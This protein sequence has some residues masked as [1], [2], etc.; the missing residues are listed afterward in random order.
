MRS[1]IIVVMMV[2]VLVLVA[3][4][5]YFKDST[6][7]RLELEE[8]PESVDDSFLDIYIGSSLVAA[9][10]EL[11]KNP[12]LPGLKLIPDYYKKSSG[13]TIPFLSEPPPQLAG[14]DWIHG[15]QG[16]QQ[17]QWFPPDWQHG[18]ESWQQSRL[19]GPSYLHTP[20]GSQQ[21]ILVPGGYTIHG[22]VGQQQ[23]NLYPNS[24]VHMGEPGQY[25]SLYYDPNNYQHIPEG[26]TQSELILND[27]EHADIEGPFHSL[28][29]PPESIHIDDG[30]PMDSWYILGGPD[31]A[32]HV[33]SGPM[34][35]Y[36]L[37]SGS[38]HI[39]SDENVVGCPEQD[40]FWVP[41][42]SEHS[43]SP[44]AYSQWMYLRDPGSDIGPI[45]PWIPE[46]D[47]PEDFDE[48]VECCEM[49][50][51]IT[52]GEG[53]EGCEDFCSTCG[54]YA[55]ELIA[56]CPEDYYFTMANCASISFCQGGLPKGEVGS[57]SARK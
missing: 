33:D 52:N 8:Y 44:D 12:L 46:C 37:P 49:A 35:S 56:L 55:A 32:D 4:F 51:E 53:V 40:S 38:K 28:Y 13:D 7:S 23:S 57:N 10:Q 16:N 30:G 42:S 9:G 1:L 24:W 45:I 54:Q 36:W 48:I 22:T 6:S 41:P 25:L 50:E 17:S 3:S 47:Y 34:E 26:I 15:T 21:S 20:G 11:S 39:G 14:P 31:N 5:I 29:L 27:W 19:F 18:T 2:A 43:V